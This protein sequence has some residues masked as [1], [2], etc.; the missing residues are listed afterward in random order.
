MFSK[1][2]DS[3][4]SHRR[5]RGYVDLAIPSEIKLWLHC[6]RT[7]ADIQLKRDNR[8]SKAVALS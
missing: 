7:F 2:I 1:C 5:L 3:T 6:D 8:I 4:Y